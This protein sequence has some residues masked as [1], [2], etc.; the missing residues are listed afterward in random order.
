MRG[1]RIGQIGVQLLGIGL[2]AV[3]TAGTSF[4]IFKFLKRF[5]GLRVSAREELE[6]YDLGGVI[7]PT[8][9]RPD[10]RTVR[11]LMDR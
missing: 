8:E 7:T 9:E 4:I 1:T 11:E 2:C 3:W 6:G 10:E 5:V